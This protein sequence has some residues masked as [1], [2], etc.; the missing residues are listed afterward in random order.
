MLEM[1]DHQKSA[2]R[3]TRRPGI[4]LRAQ[5]SR[6]GDRVFYCNRGVR[7]WIMDAQWLAENG[8]EWPT[9]VREVDGS[10][11]EAFKPGRRVARQWSDA[12]W[13]NPPRISTATLREICVSKL[14]GRGVEIGAGTSPMPVPLDCEVQYADIFSA[15]QLV[16][17]FYDG[18]V[19]SDLIVPDLVASFENLSVVPDE[20]LDFIVA[21]HVIEHTSDPIGAIVRGMRKLKSGG[22]M[23]LVIPDMTRTFDRERSLTT[24]SHLIEDFE[25]PSRQSDREHF[26]EFYRL[27]MPVDPDE[28]AD[29]WFA[30]WLEAFPIHYHV[31]TYDSFMEVIDW[32]S[33]N[34]QQFSEIWSQPTL[35]C[36][37]DCIEFYCAI[38][39]L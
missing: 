38:K 11:L 33:R 26:K 3:I 4:L 25:C 6:F 36:A 23:S 12:D 19:P 16:D 14:T 29:Y 20:S 22:W 1:T 10:I 8:F 15:D 7:H 5:S 2:F 18:Q 21:C 27:A 34:V 35:D 9:D 39:K 13:R 31:W 24:L 17:H 37:P 30:R 32:V 28:Y